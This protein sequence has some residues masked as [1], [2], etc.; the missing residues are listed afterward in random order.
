MKTQQRLSVDRGKN[1][2]GRRTAATEG[3]KLF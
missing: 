2:G 1:F 3:V